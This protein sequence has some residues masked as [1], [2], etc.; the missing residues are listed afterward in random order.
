MDVR[1]KFVLSMIGLVLF[2]VAL[3]IVVYFVV[4]DAAVPDDTTAP[5]R[6]GTPGQSDPV[7]GFDNIL[8]GEPD[9]EEE[10]EESNPGLTLSP[11]E[12]PD[13]EEPSPRGTEQ[14]GE[15]VYTVRML[16]TWNKNVH[17]S[18]YP[19]GAHLSPMVAWSHRPGDHIYA[20][21]KSAS[22]GVESVAETG[23]PR[24]IEREIH[25]VQNEGYI[26]D[27]AIGKKIYAPGEDMVQIRVAEHASNITVIS[28]IAPSPD[29]FVAAK[30]IS[31]FEN[32]SWVERK[33]YAAS[34]YDSGTDSG[35][36]FSARDIDTN[37]KESIDL[38]PNQP[39]V[40]IVTFEFVREH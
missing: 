21:G 11:P 7:L 36:T 1:V 40:P 18:W 16:G 25:A 38:L 3:S 31:L 12:T 22:I 5:A 30:N 9:P 14:L 2:I 26:L 15:Q 23:S 33:Q 32:G 37:P 39:D 28:M 10:T 13:Q 24:R 34:I 29:W 35:E 19:D 17:G 8:G 20:L 27:Y 6:I 4:R